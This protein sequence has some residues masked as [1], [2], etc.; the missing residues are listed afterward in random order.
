M[1]A[2][3]GTEL[4]CRV[5]KLGCN[6]DRYVQN[7]LVSMYGKL[8][9]LGD[10]KKV[11]DEMTVKN[12][13]T[14]NALSSAHGVA[15]D[16][17]GAEGVYQ[18]APARNI[19]WW[20]MEITRNVRLGDMAEAARMFMAMPE[21]DAVSWNSMIGGYAKIGMHDRALG[22]FQEMQENGIELTEVTVVSTLG[23]CAELGELE[24]GRRIHSS[25]ASKGIAADGYVGNALVDM[26]AK[27][28]SLKLARQVFYG[29]TIRDATC[30]NAMIIGL[31][32]HGHSREA[33]NLFDS[34]NIE[35]DHVTFLGVLTACS[36]GGLVNEGRSYF[37]S[38]IGDYKI[39]PSMKHY[40]CM[41]DM[42]CRYGE[43]HEAYRMI[44]D[45]PIKANSMLWKM[46]MAACRV[47]GHFDLANKAFHE[48]H[49]LMPL[50]DGGVITISNAYAQA[51]WWDDVE[52]LRTKVIGSSASKHAA[53]S[54]VHVR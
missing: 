23:S 32:F 28:G 1:F 31:S 44:K 5:L 38:M 51:K 4:H 10:A 17:E 39:V 47:H 26:Y 40:G 12:A 35:P 2:A 15:G 54:Q 30:W 53:L 34:M 14:W 45:M 52:H 41:I 13:V 16:F 48:L 19:S 6:E 20:N 46:V 24:L 25:L 21:R 7:A 8:C 11:F 22:V 9:L 36:H 43:V 18:A 3:K 49:Q 27:C 50:D 33:L 29:M 37:S 42:L